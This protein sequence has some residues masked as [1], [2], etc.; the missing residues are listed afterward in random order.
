M[1]YIIAGEFTASEKIY[2]SF[3]TNIP[4]YILYFFSFAGLLGICYWIDQSNEGQ[5]K[6]K[7]LG[8]G[9]DGIGI[10]GVAIALSLAFG[11]FTLVTLLGYA[12]VMIPKKWW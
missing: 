5:N 1:G 11:Y 8:T 10:V 6:V 2:R 7:L 3:V 9:K 12:L 4:Y